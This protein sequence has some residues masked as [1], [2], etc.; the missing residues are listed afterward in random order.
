M[1]ALNPS[2]FP[3]TTLVIHLTTFV[4]QALYSSSVI[5]MLVRISFVIVTLPSTVIDSHCHMKYDTGVA[6]SS[7]LL[8]LSALLALSSSLFTAPP[9]PN[10]SGILPSTAIEFA[11]SPPRGLPPS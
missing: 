5:A 6:S 11:S 3:S 8:N 1:Y 4:I 9:P 10:S 7:S 2:R